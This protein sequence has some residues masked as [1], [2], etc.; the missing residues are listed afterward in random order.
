MGYRLIFSKIKKEKNYA[1]LIPAIE[2]FEHSP[3]MMTRA[4]EIMDENYDFDHWYKT[5]DEIKDIID[6]LAIQIPAI[7]FYEDNSNAVKD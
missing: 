5:M 1:A 3:L 4:I 2:F 6:H 7:S